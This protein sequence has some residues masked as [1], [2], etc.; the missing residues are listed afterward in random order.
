MVISEPRQ[1]D[2]FRRQSKVATPIAL[3]V[4]GVLAVVFVVTLVVLVVGRIG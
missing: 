3:I 2:R 1:H 4:I